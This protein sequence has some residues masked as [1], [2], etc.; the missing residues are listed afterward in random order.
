MSHSIKLS[1]SCTGN[2]R[3]TA[4]PR[5]RVAVEGQVTQLVGLAAR[6]GCGL[7]LQ[8]SWEC[9]RSLAQDT[10]TEELLPFHHL[11]VDQTAQAL[12]QGK[13]SLTVVPASACPGAC[14]VTGGRSGR[15]GLAC[16]APRA[17]YLYVAKRSN[18]TFLPKPL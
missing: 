18:F 16:L 12:A 7:V 3:L 14:R 10:T 1:D 15:H 6:P 17:L 13:S 8:G 5:L 11:S 9:V 2:M 4:V